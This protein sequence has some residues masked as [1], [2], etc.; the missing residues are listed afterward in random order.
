MVSSYGQLN[1][2]GMTR[3]SLQPAVRG[4]LRLPDNHD[5][6]LEDLC[7]GMS[8]RVKP[9]TIGL[10]SLIHPSRGCPGLAKGIKRQKKNFNPSA[11]RGAEVCCNEEELL[12]GSISRSVTFGGE[13]FCWGWPRPIGKAET[14]S[15]IIRV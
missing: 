1:G 6:L 4:Y 14:K 2:V 5:E 9:S 10:L 3:F 11:L 12:A 15:V 13:N 7:S 8:S